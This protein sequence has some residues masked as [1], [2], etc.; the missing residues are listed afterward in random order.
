M[1]NKERIRE[2]LGDA[3]ELKKVE[4]AVAVYRDLGDY[5][6]VIRCG[7][8]RTQP[9]NIYVWQKYPYFDVVERHLSVF[10]YREDLRAICE[11]IVKRYAGTGN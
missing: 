2:M 9:V 4:G 6:I 8:R 11:G 10:P 5:E 7:Q 3:W 1:T